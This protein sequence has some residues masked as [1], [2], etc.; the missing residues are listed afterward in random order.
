MNARRI[1][2]IALTIVLVVAVLTGAVSAFSVNAKPAVRAAL[3]NVRDYSPAVTAN[4]LSYAVD[5]GALFAGQPGHW[6]QVN[7]P[8]N[9]IAGAVVADSQNPELVY[10]GPAN[11]MAIY[12]STDGG[13]D[14]QRIPLSDQYIGGVTDI[15]LDSIQRLVYVGTDTA[16]IFR[17]RDTGSSVI[18]GG[19]LLLE[20]PVLE[21]A[22]DSTGKGMAFARTEW[23]LYRAENFG[24]AWT[25]VEGLKSVPT[26]LAIANSEPAK[27][28]VGTMDRGL[29][30]SE[31]GLT[32]TPANEG[33]G[34]VPGSRLHITDVAADPLQPEVVYA[35]TSFIYGTSEA[36]EAPGMVA[37]T[38]DG[39]EVWT[40]VVDQMETLVADLMPLPGMTGAVYALTDQSR[41]P[42]ALGNAPVVTEVAVAP[43]PVESGLSVT[44]LL[45]WVVAALAAF[46]LIFAVASDLRS[47]RL[48]PTTRLAAS[49]VRNH[50]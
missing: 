25:L 24:L 9:V 3:A 12:R 39:A 15:A 30:V 14:W 19:Q 43:A 7:T 21:V 37:M 26:A 5:G 22:A 28:Y 35:A 18:L 6:V 17:L 49:P 16:G 29:L 13:D 2:I 45:A 1:A 20:E 31:D 44:G 36:H 50:R 10:L 4:S 8:A 46:A 48:E 41:T 38:V 11:E 34:L 33:L 32:W 40:P 23:N 27:V 47:R 42:L